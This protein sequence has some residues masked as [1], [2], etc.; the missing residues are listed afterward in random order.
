MGGI[1]N[2]DLSAKEKIS[3]ARDLA[4]SGTALLTIIALACLT[5]EAELLEQIDGLHLYLTARQIEV[6]AA[7]ALLFLIVFAF[8]WWL[9]VLAM[10]KVV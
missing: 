7:I 3:N 2:A 8:C 1:A 4:S 5:L 6:E 9:S 10:G